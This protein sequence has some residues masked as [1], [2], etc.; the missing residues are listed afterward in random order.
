MGG[1]PEDIV[2]F[3]AIMTMEKP[4]KYHSEMGNKNGMTIPHIATR[5]NHS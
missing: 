2:S 5:Q 3:P 4:Q 1:A